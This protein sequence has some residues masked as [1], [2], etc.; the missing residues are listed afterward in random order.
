MKQ[1][2]PRGLFGAKALA[3]WI[4]EGGRA[5]RRIFAYRA[6]LRW[7]A[8]W[9][10][11]NWRHQTRRLSA[12]ELPRDPV[13]ILGLWRCGTTVLHELLT[14]ATRWATPQTWQ[15]FNPSTCFL[16]G[17]PPRD[18]AV[19]RPMDRGTITT[20]SPQED[21]FALLL[22]GG[23]SAYRAFIDP[24]RLDECAASLLRTQESDLARWQDFTRGLVAAEGAPRLLL[25]SPG[26]T[27]RVP[28][29]R[30][31]FPS[32][33]FVFIG[34]HAGEVLESNMR[35]WRAMTDA[36]ALWACPSGALERFLREALGAYVRVVEQCIEEMPPERM[37]WIDFE[38]LQS[39]PGTALRSVL[40]FLQVP[41][42][43]MDTLVEEALA[44]VPVHPG[45]RVERPSEPIVERLETLRKA[46]RRRFAASKPCR[47][48]TGAPR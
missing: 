13:F 2:T 7:H 44:R 23:A 34:R 20:R 42:E 8:H 25:K 17:A 12:I 22:L 38:T 26:H 37:T 16:M 18:A 29:L 35:M 32:A 39:D 48:G 31:L 43:G 30:E 40:R 14:A 5:E 46:A 45:R 19:E 21:E 28:L 33:K 36:Y 11:L 27:F 9:F 47:P 6:Q 41:E 10:E 15:C 24:R 3:D 4:S 1:A